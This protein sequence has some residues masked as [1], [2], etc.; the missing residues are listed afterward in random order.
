[1]NQ[2][3]HN[4]EKIIKLFKELPVIE[5]QRSI[6]EVYRN[7]NRRFPKKRQRKRNVLIPVLSGMAALILCVLL[8]PNFLQESDKISYQQEHSHDQSGTADG[9]VEVKMKVAEE[10]NAEIATEESIDHA[11]QSIKEDSEM[12][13]TTDFVDTS[14]LTSVY[15]HDLLDNQ[16]A[17]FGMLTKQAFVVPISV[18]VPQNSDYSWSDIYKNAATTLSQM[19]D[20]FMDYGPLI[21]AIKIDEQNRAAY[22][23][24]EHDFTYFDQLHNNLTDLVTYTLK[25]EYINIDDVHFTNNDSEPIEMG[26]FGVVQPIEN[27]QT[28]TNKVQFLYSEDNR[29]YIVPDL[30]A[31]AD[32]FADAI[33]M[34]KQP[35]NDFLTS[36]IP[37][38]INPI[39]IGDDR[40]TVTV[41]FN[42]DL[43][44][45]DADPQ[46]FSYMM[47][48]IL[49]SAKEF[50][51]RAVK[52]ENI[53]EPSHWREQHF[54][55]PI[56]VPVSPNVVNR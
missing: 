32:S 31:T 44:F 34:M 55:E 15:R 47:E 41:G 22:I 45:D 43:T 49:L 13:R 14:V 53:E 8:I 54:D 33:G 30:T 17:T 9:D 1:M 7:L 52:F 48:A 3:D 39:V 42:H 11:E 40:G 56:E 4:D 24:L 23:N 51:Y 19:N 18:L 35:P 12:N 38:Q 10:D 50:G 27:L 29:T 25:N 28:P 5:D 6:D 20:N 2:Q 46:T 37:E 16:V 21:D 36:A 26:E